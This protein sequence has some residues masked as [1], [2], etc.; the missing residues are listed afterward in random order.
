[1]R[2]TLRAEFELNHLDKERRMQQLKDEKELRVFLKQY[3]NSMAQKIRE[4]YPH[5]FDELMA[6]N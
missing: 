3:A 2:K 1:M 5:E 6:A 4:L